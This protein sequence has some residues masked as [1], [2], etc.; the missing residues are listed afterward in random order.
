MQQNSCGALPAEAAPQWG[1]D[2]VSVI[3]DAV[4]F[5]RIGEIAAR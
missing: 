2:F 4:S 1:G 5:S 3:R